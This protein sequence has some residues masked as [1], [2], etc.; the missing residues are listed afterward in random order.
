CQRRH[1]GATTGGLCAL[2]SSCSLSTCFIRTVAAHLRV[3]QLAHSLGGAVATVSVDL[4]SMSVAGVYLGAA[5]GPR[6][7]ARVLRHVRSL[8]RGAR[9]SGDRPG[10]YDWRTQER[11]RRLSRTMAGARIWIHR[12]VDGRAV[13]GGSDDDRREGIH[14]MALGES[15]S[16]TSQ[17]APCESGAVRRVRGHQ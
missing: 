2:L 9:E 16:S 14:G 13:P 3:D 17:G 4:D 12:L 15:V 10:E 5:A 11:Q 6:P 1:I 8:S 7:G